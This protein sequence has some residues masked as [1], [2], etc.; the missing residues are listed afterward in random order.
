MRIAIP[1][2]LAVLAS[3]GTLAH[4]SQQEEAI[5][6]PS[7]GTGGSQSQTEPVA[8]YRGSPRRGLGSL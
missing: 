8:V 4:T 5:P 6:A 3:V 1:I 2:S 7:G